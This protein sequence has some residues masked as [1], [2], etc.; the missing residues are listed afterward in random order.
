MSDTSDPCF[1]CLETKSI[2]VDI[3]EANCRLVFQL[4]EFARNLTDLLSAHPSSINT[5][6]PRTNAVESED[7][8]ARRRREFDEEA[9][10]QQAAQSPASQQ[11]AA[12]QSRPKL[13]LQTPSLSP[14]II[15]VS[16]PA[17]DG[18]HSANTQSSSSSSARPRLT[19]PFT[20]SANRSPLLSAMPNMEGLTTN[21]A[22][23]LADDEARALDE[24]MRVRRREREAS[25]GGVSG[26]P[27]GEG[28]GLTPLVV[29]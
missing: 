22:W 6:F 25:I 27:G 5:S 13:G 28:K 20:S 23:E 29:G 12:P 26:N 9:A 19:L 10:T 17:R 11:H 3:A 4:V 15:G 14:P 16:T 8:W 18:L 21:E 1:P 2:S 7:D 24:A